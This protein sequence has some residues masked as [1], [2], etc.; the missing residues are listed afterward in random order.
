[1]SGNREEEMKGQILVIGGMREDVNNQIVIK[2]T[3][4]RLP[5]SKSQLCHSPI[6]S[7]DNNSTYLIMYYSLLNVN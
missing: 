7:G 1:M 4:I 3:V 5:G 6:K 2:T